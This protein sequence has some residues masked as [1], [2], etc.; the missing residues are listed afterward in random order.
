MKKLFI[1]IGLP[2]T[3]TSSVQNFLFNNHKFLDEHGFCYIKTGLSES[4]KCHHD[5]IWKLGLHVGPS[6]VEKDIQKYK[7]E[8]LNSLID[9]N[10]KYHDKDLIFSSE[11]LT[12]LDDYE[13]LNP[14][15]EIFSNREIKFIVNIRRQDRFL[16]S[17][18]Q[19]IVKDGTS[20]SFNEWLEQSREVANYNKLINRVLK[21]TS[22]ENIIIDLFDTNSQKLFPVEKFLILLGFDEEF[23]LKME[24]DN[25]IENESLSREQIEI[26]RKSNKLDYNARYKLL[27]KFLSDNKSN[28]IMK[29]SYLNN[30]EIKNI[31]S[32]FRKSNNALI[33]LMDLSD[34][35][36]SFANVPISKKRDI[37]Y[38]IDHMDKNFISGWCF[39]KN[40][41]E[42]TIKLELYI[43]N[44]KMYE[45][46]ANKFRKDFFENA[47]HPTGNLGFQFN[48]DNKFI[49]ETSSVVLKIKGCEYI[50]K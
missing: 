2:K 19:Q 25:S 10:K 40:N 1:H 26:I 6:Y 41:M 39:D 35:I 3:A 9:E 46:E 14:I 31:I 49:E 43:D 23:I 36:A 16:E 21:I 34:N 37:K 13:K 33:E 11:L 50:L 30:K 28:S 22:K 38:H 32:S 42:N 27:E 5:I 15:L 44:K 24:I 7:D 18:Y 29:A 17:L 4:L 48:I 8:I 20:L 47:T 12:F 45:E